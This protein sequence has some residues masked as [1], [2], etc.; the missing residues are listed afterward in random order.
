MDSRGE[1]WGNDGTFNM[2]YDMV[3]KGLCMNFCTIEKK[4][5]NGSISQLEKPTYSSVT[6]KKKKKGKKKRRKR[7]ISEDSVDSLSEYE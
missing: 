5:S 6:K 3:T 4:V 7:N 1:S 2:H